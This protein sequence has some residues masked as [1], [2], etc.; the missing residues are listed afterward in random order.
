MSLLQ[1][2]SRLA[3]SGNNIIRAHTPESRVDSAISR[4]LKEEKRWLYEE[5]IVNFL[6]SSSLLQ[7]L[8]MNGV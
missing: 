7:K 6:L 3:Q 8:K 4:E 1:N 5:L 2:P